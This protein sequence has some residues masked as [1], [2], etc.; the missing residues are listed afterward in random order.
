[1]SPLDKT[2]YTP[3]MREVLRLSKAEAG[4]LGHDYIG[5]EHYMLGIIRK[6]DGLAVTALQ[7][8]DVD[9]DEIKSEIEHA[10]EVGSA[11]EVGLFQPNNDAKRVLDQVR[12]VAEEMTHGW[13]GTEHLLLAL[14]RCEETL[15]AKVLTDHGVNFQRAQQEVMA[16]IEGSQT[17]GAGVSTGKKGS[18]KS[19]EKSKTPA[20]DTFG[21]DLTQLAREGKLDPVIG[22]ADEIERILQILCRRTKNNPVLLGE[23]GVGKT[24]IVE[25]LAQ[26]IIHNDVPDL[27]ANK[28]V[29]SLD[30]AAVVAGTKYRGQFEERLKAIMQ[31][32]RKN[33]DIIL[34]ID[35]LHTIVG[36]GAAE[37]AI[38]AS[39]MLK[40]ALSR[41][42]V[43]CVGATTLEEY[44]KYIEKDGALERRFQTII[45]DAP[46]I[47]ETIQILKGLRSRYEA[48][49]QVTITDE[50]LDA[51]ARLSDRYVSD[52]CLPDKAI[53]LMDEAGARAHLQ[54]HIKPQE[55]KDVDA[56][57]FE[58][59]EKI[60]ILA[61]Q[62]A[63]EKCQVL[64][65]DKI[66]LLEKRERLMREWSEHLKES[67]ETGAI[68]EEE[69][70][71][72]ASKWTGIPVQRLAEAETSRLMRME[73]ELRKRVI[74]QTEAIETLSR[75]I[76]RTRAGLKAPNRPTGSFIFLG[77]TGV[78]KTELAKALAEFLFG[79]ED[80]LVRIDMSE[81]MEKF[82]V[83]RLIGAPPGY[84]GYE[85]GGQLTK[86]IRQKPYSVVLLDEIEKAH[87]DVFS[88]MLQVLDDGR[89]T[90]SFGHV[91]DFK[92][93]VIIM[94]SNI[95]TKQLKNSG[96][97][98]FKS[99]DRMFE[100][101]EIKK[102]VLSEV[103]KVFNP[104]FLNR[105]DDI[106]VFQ[107]LTR[108]DIAKIV[109]LMLK[110]LNKRVA[111]HGLEVQ[112]SEDALAFLIEK[113]YDN[114][115]GA[116]PMR[117]AIQRYI[118]DP[119]SQ[120]MIA[121]KIPDDVIVETT[122]TEDGQSLHFQPLAR[123]S[124]LKAQLAQA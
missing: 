7:N 98:G 107:S 30:L 81:Y 69:I 123:E 72:I 36:A 41:G 109:T 18:S 25:G 99:H 77:P 114:E 32:L 80:A 86:K 2:P 17:A 66:A 65:D 12:R 67:H 117:R 64:K 95:G 56:R 6:G 103:R 46:S 62:Q 39:N 113:G 13:I 59:E 121:G 49:H 10:L 14:I 4:R 63:F 104:E 24:A 124:K 21:R 100:H 85:E 55:V 11:S 51:A 87:P 20:L 58:M 15:P 33:R 120:L 48:H 54:A 122:V 112:L 79:D 35:E 42:E 19:G 89:L 52:R 47:E 9:L 78:G 61:K 111:E 27:L 76:R 108:E 97:I 105:I 1:M 23:P 22:R 102:K 118:E 68:G 40:P 28:R 110:D 116:R 31:E 93:T 96:S 45:V 43:Q 44:R 90:D 82:A 70:A 88:L 8:M 16:V 74:S 92:N 34:F 106:I 29:L 115:Y 91:V 38:D 84:V 57:I 26:R 53:D 3:G 75:A 119:L 94:T 101:E 50:A 5:P 71:F 73:E 83:S 37:G 60:A